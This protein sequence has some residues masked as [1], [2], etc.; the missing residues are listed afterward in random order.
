MRFLSLLKLLICCVFSF[1]LFGSVTVL[2]AIH[3]K[4]VVPEIFHCT[5]GAY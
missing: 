4:G 3:F 2:G 5:R 1:Y